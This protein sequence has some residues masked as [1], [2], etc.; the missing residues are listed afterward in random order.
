MLLVALPHTLSNVLL[1]AIFLLSA[2]LPLPGAGSLLFI[3]KS[4]SSPSVA[5]AVSPRSRVTSVCVPAFTIASRNHSLSIPYHRVAQFIRPH[6]GL[7]LVV[8]RNQTRKSL[9]LKGRASLLGNA[10]N[11]EAQQC[12]LPAGAQG[13]VDASSVLAQKFLH[14][15]KKSISCVLN[16][17][18]LASTGNE[19]SVIR[20]QR[21]DERTSL[22]C[23]LN[24]AARLHRCRF[25]LNSFGRL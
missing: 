19:N 21:S 25:W 24:D 7:S 11:H 1:S 9:S 13:S 14:G 23:L 4:F 12:K 8:A 2:G 22:Y 10:A 5:F 17:E 6:R 18:Q 16:S 3:F 20:L 15:T